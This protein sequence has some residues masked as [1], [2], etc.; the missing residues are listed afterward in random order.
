MQTKCI[1]HTSHGSSLILNVSMLYMLLLYQICECS[2][3]KD[4]ALC[5]FTSEIST[6]YLKQRQSTVS[7]HEGL[8][9]SNFL[10]GF[11]WND[12]TVI[13]WKGFCIVCLFI[14]LLVIRSL[15]F[16]LLFSF[17]ILKNIR[18]ACI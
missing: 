18:K 11:L 16:S 2:F 12:K 4:K 17:C 6:T 1:I 8:M 15:K 13:S 14:Y 10:K 9:K 7:W 3:F 5:N